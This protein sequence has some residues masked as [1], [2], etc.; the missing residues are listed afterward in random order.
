[1]PRWKCAR[2]VRETDSQPERERCGPGARPASSRRV[3]LSGGLRGHG[4]G[5]LFGVSAVSGTV[6]SG[7][8]TQP[9]STFPWYRLPHSVFLLQNKTQLV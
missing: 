8:S 2:D 7:F 1:M 9:S 5:T 4:L 6:E 3:V